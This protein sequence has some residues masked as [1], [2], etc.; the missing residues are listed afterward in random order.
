MYVII[1]IYNFYFGENMSTIARINLSLSKIPEFL[2]EYKDIYKSH[3]RVLQ[4][5]GESALDL[6]IS[7]AAQYNFFA[8]LLVEMR[9]L[10]KFVRLELDK[11]EGQLYKKFNENMNIDLSHAQ[12]Q[13]YMKSEPEYIDMKLIVIEVEEL[14]EKY[15]NLMDA[16]KAKGFVLN[17]ITKLL[18]TDTGNI[19]F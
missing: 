18:A 6:N 11:I 8:E 16:L 17:N 3:N 4:T 5:S 19:I 13:T 14:C 10:R 9:T 12:I 2:N 7:H 1:V 15:E